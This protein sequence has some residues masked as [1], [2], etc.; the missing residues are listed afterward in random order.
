MLVGLQGDGDGLWHLAAA[1][2]A[3]RV[4][5][6][7]DAAAWLAEYLSRSR[8]PEPGGLVLGVTGGL[9]GCRS[10]DGRRLDRPGGCRPRRPGAADRR[11]PGGGGLE[12]A[13]A[14][15]D[16]PGLRWPDLAGASGSIDPAQLDDAAADGRGILLLVVAGNPG[17]G[18]GR[19]RDHRGR[20]LDAARRGCE[21]AVVDI[22]RGREALRSFAWECDRI[23]VVVPA[24]LRAAVATARLLQELPPVDTVLG[25]PGQSR[26]RLGCAADRG[27]RGA[28]PARQSC[29]KSRAWPAAT[30]LGRLLEAGRQRAVRRF[31]AGVPWSGRG[32]RL[33]SA[34]AAGGPAEP[35]RSARRAS[36]RRRVQGFVDQTLLESV[37]ESVMADA[38]PVTPSRV[39]A[40]VQA[41]GRL[42]GTAGALAA[43]GEH[44]RGTERPG[45]PA[46][47]H[48]GSGRDG[49]LRQRAGLGLAGPRQRTG[50]GARRLLRESQIRALA[51]RLVAAGG[52]R[53][54]DGSPCVDVRLDGG[55]RVHAVLPPISTAGT[56]LSV[57]I[58]RATVF[59]MSELRRDGMFG[60]DIRGPGPVRARTH[61][62]APAEL[63]DQ[64]RH[65][66]G[67][68]HVTG[69][70][71]GVVPP[72]RDG[73]S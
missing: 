19:G 59:S 73:S 4:A 57:R 23:V 71:A 25:G 38:A 47:A 36:G 49:H 63:P 26:C 42:L 3:E 45:P 50:A 67:E 72:R 21:L 70:A 12:L 68:D 16:V 43:V 5:V 40:A 7:P 65:R 22:G 32:R 6:L 2:G 34:H 61:G 58:R 53:L 15:E 20:V 17:T 55:Y 35:E 31:A 64:R 14:A 52:R 48:P 44:Q 39:A 66:L 11:R 10:H 13:L 51:A 30:E 27:V 8:A 1:I 33:V 41:S 28:S 46:T 54:D 60:R 62:G 24:R 37:R 69:D 18:R 29:R 9:R 56:L